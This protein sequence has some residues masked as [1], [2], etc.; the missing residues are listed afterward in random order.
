VDTADEALTRWQY[1]WAV[2][3]GFVNGNAQAD[4]QAHGDDENTERSAMRSRG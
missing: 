1:G 4:A 2:S 3:V